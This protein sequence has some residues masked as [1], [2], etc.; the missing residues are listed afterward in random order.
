MGALTITVRRA[1]L[2]NAGEAPAHRWAGLRLVLSVALVGAAF[3]GVLPR[4]A[5]YEDAWERLADAR[6][7][8]IGLVVLAAA[9][10]LASYWPLLMLALPGLT[11][12]QAALSTQVS[13]AVANTVPA[14]GAWGAGLTIAMYRRW[15]FSGTEVARAL[16]VTGVWNIG[17]KLVLGLAAALAL[18]ATAE[19]DA[20]FVVGATSAALLLALVAL[21]TLAVRRPGPARA[22]VEVAERAAGAVARLRRRTPPHGW[23]LVADRLRRDIGALVAMRWRRLTLAAVVSHLSLFA[24][25]LVAMHAAGLTGVSIME[26]LGVFSVVRVALV[27]PL[28]P[29]GA[30]IAEVGLSALIVTAGGGRPEAVAAV[31]L[32]RAVTWGLPVVLGALAWLLWVHERHAVEAKRS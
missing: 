19:G 24:V 4:I 29:G 23:T 5:S 7:A 30:G 15:G 6:R 18:L 17:T 11:V 28:T 13:T 14:G 1:A 32:Y 2:G 8:E 21:V 20:S 31:L 10:N 25:L 27:I 3:L 22:V 26:A 9:W 12:R 16:L